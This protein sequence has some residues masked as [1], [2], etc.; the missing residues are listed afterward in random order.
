[1]TL[2][3]FALACWIERLLAAGTAADQ[4]GFALLT[5]LTALALLEH[6]L[7]ILPLPDAKLWRW[8]IPAPKTTPKRLL[9]EDGHGL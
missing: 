1:M 9:R 5:G 2:L 6:W 3:T 7:L 4:A 8:M